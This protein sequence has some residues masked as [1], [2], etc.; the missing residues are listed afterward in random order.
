MKPSR[1]PYQNRVHKHDAK[2]II[3]QFG[4]RVECRY[5]HKIFLEVITSEVI[6]N[7]N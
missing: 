7:E 1:Y 5:C 3:N 6:T 4:Y 2:V